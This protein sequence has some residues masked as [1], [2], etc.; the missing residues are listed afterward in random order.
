AIELVEQLL[1][2]A[3]VDPCVH[4]ASGHAK[5]DRGAETESLVLADIVVGA[6]VTAL[7]GALLH[8]VERLQAGNDFTARENT[9]VELAASHGAQAIGQDSGTTENSVQALRE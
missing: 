8:G 4:L 9:N 1:A 2:A 5:R 7:D 3:V 6:G